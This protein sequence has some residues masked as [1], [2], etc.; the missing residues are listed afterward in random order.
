MCSGSSTSAILQGGDHE[1]N[2]LSFVQS[3]WLATLWWALGAFLVPCTESSTLLSVRVATAVPGISSS[4]ADEGDLQYKTEYAKSNRA[5]CKACKGIIS[6]ETL[7]MARMV[8]SPHFDGKVHHFGMLLFSLES[9]MCGVLSN[10]SD[11]YGRL[12]TFSAQIPHWYHFACFFKKFRPPSTGDVAG[13]HSLRWEDQKR[14]EGAL[15]SGSGTSGGGGVK[16]KG[17]GKSEGAMAQPTPTLEKR[18][19]LMVEYA[20]SGRSKCRKCYDLIEQVSW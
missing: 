7:R 20:R 10:D 17:K 2:Q 11:L 9:A 4:M 5:S 1:G 18:D 13:F 6:K 14:I 8:Q 15:S 12:L 16:K 19:D 3:D